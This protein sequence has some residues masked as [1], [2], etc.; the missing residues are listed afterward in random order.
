MSTKTRRTIEEIE[1]GASVD[2]GAI[3]DSA[4]TDPTANASMIAAL[5]GLLKQLQ[6]DGSGS[7]PITLA[8]S[9]SS[10]YDTIDIAKMSK[11]GVTTAHDAIT[12][13]ATSAEMDWRGFNAVSVECIVSDITSG[14]WAIEVLGCAI[15]GGTFGRQWDSNSREAKVIDLDTNETMTFVF[16]DIANYGQIRATRTTDGTLTCKVTPMNI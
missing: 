9:L 5:K 1:T 14:N 2:I 3:D 10:E 13:T 16:R 12:A 15:S 6:G 4:V 11:G 7:A 8:T